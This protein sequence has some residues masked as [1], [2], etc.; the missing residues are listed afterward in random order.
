M[1]LDLEIYLITLFEPVSCN[2]IIDL[3]FWDYPIRVHDGQQSQFGFCLHDSLYQI[4]SP[5]IPIWIKTKE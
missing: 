2:P 3:Y 5:Q 1:I 4:N